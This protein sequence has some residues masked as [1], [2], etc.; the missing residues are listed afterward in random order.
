M[1]RLR[2]IHLFPLICLALGLGAG[3]FFAYIALAFPET[4]RAGAHL[5]VPDQYADCHSC[6]AKTTPVQ[7]QDWLDS[8][9]GVMLVKCV[10]CHGMPDGKGSIPFQARPESML[11]CVRCHDPSI[12]AMQA[13]FGVNADCYTCHPSHQNPMHRKAY[14][15][16]Q[17]TDKVSF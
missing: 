6:H 11:I 7:A 10:V 9:H 15:S 17:A 12:K 4:R 2:K 1:T 3:G 13:K 5:E 14:E 8:K 16:K